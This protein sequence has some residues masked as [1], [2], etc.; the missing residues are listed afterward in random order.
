MQHMASHAQRHTHTP[1]MARQ[2]MK[3]LPTFVFRKIKL[4]TEMH[5]MRSIYD[6]DRINIWNNWISFEGILPQQYRIH[7]NCLSQHQCM[8]WEWE[9]VSLM[10]IGHNQPWPRVMR[11]VWNDAQTINKSIFSESIIMVHGIKSLLILTTNDLVAHNP[12]KQN[13]MKKKLK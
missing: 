5:S 3:R 6:R 7:L 10:F 1:Y 2:Q 4:Q 11:L 13:G 9:S 12:T 8:N